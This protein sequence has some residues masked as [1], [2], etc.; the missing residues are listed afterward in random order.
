MH[1]VKIRED[2][3]SAML[4]GGRDASRTNP[5]VPRLRAELAAL[6]AQRR[7]LD[8]R[9]RAQVSDGAAET[10]GLSETAVGL[11]DPEFINGVFVGERSSSRERQLSVLRR[12]TAIQTRELALRGH[13]PLHEPGLGIGRIYIPPPTDLALPQPVVTKALEAAVSGAEVSLPTPN[14]ATARIPDSGRAR[15]LNAVEV[16]C[17]R[18]RQVVLGEPGAGKSSLLRFVAHA[19]ATRQRRLL[20]HWPQGEWGSVP[21]VLHLGDL[22][23]WL[24]EQGGDERSPLERFWE[25]IRHDFAERNLGFALD[26]LQEAFSEGRVVLLIDGFDEVPLNL[27]DTVRQGIMDLQHQ[28][29]HCR[30]VISCRS[31]PYGHAEWRLPESEFP[32]TVLRGL[33]PGQIDRFVGDWF[34]EMSYCGRLFVADAEH[35]AE[36][37]RAELKRGQLARLAPN[38]LDLTLMALD[39]TSR[40]EVADSRARLFDQALHLMLAR[41]DREIDGSEQGRVSD[42]LWAARR[43]RSDLIGLFERIAFRFQGG[44]KGPELAS[45]GA[46]SGSGGQGVLSAISESLLVNSIAPLHPGKDVAWAQAVVDLLKVNPGLLREHHPGVYYFV[47]RSVREYLSGCHLA[48]FGAF[49]Q[50]GTALADARCS[51]RESILHAVGFIIHIQREPARALELVERLCPPDAS[52][53]QEGWRRVWLAGAVMHEIGFSRAGDTA[54]GIRALERVRI[55]LAALV[56][57][58]RLDVAERAAAATYLARL[59]DPRFEP[60]GFRLSQRFRGEKEKALGL[61]MVRPGALSMGTREDR[62][63]PA[64]LPNERGNLAPLNLDYNIW[65]ERYPVT[66]AQYRS[67]VRARGYERREWWT[68]AGWAW[69]QQAGRSEPAGWQAQRHNGNHPVVGVNWHEALAYSHWIDAQLRKRHTKMPPGYR[70]RLPTEAEWEHLAR[71]GRDLRYPW[72]DE[73]NPDCANSLGV[74]GRTTPVG[75]FPR[76]ATPDGVLDLAGNVWEWTLSLDRPYPYD[77]ADGRNNPDAEGAR[78]LRGGSYDAP[79][80]RTRIAARSQAPAQESARDIGFRLVLSLADSAV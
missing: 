46:G 22:I 60:H 72:G 13:D 31:L 66:V 67:F 74:V 62:P 79:V 15:V 58:G 75:L 61:V 5:E 38:P 19:L 20:P 56:E 30:Y 64:A 80:E 11:F 27:L 70:M 29:P 40:G 47:H 52:L 9:L 36:R 4:S 53:D 10:L 8:A 7:E 14:A 1:A 39:F 32:V 69:C 71:R 33:D 78:I 55:R 49:A 16:I 12:L 18:R 50:L 57:S 37:F 76:G 41:M 45:A 23:A 34:A 3:P 26:A 51:W 6:E 25:F 63:D 21:W 42:L 48:H 77:P 2:K 17:L 44:G 43:D 59:G 24:S 35:Q 68:R 28:A 65:V 54:D 73:P